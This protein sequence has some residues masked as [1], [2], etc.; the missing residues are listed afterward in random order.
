MTDGCAQQ[1][2]S[3]KFLGWISERQGRRKLQRIFWESGHGKSKGDGAGGTLKVQLDQAVNARQEVFLSAEE[4]YLYCKEN[5]EYLERENTTTR[6]RLFHFLNEASTLANEKDFR[7]L[8]GT[9][10]IRQVFQLEP[11]TIGTREKACGCLQCLNFAFQNC[12]NEYTIYKPSPV[13]EQNEHEE[14]QNEDEEIQCINELT[15]GTFVA[16]EWEKEWYPGNILLK[17]EEKKS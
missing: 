3:R 5:L 13:E 6:S 11:G 12:L 1:Y 8:K 10:L 2:K 9:Q 7:P 17:F 14:E 4:V 15:I 16:V